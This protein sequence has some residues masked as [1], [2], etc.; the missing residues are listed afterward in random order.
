MIYEKVDLNSEFP[1]LP[2]GGRPAVLEVFCR[3]QLSDSA[4]AK[5]PAMIVCPGGGYWGTAAH[6]GEPVALSML[7]KGIQGFVL[8][9]T[10]PDGSWP[11][12]HL[13]LAAAVLWVRRNADRL[14]VDGN[15]ISVLG[16]SA[17]C[18]LAASFAVN[19]GDRLF[20]ETLGAEREELRVN[21][22]VLCYG[23]LMSEGKFAHEGSIRNLLKDK[24]TPEL[25]EKLSVEKNITEETP[26][27]FIWHTADDEAVPVENSLAVAAAMSAAKRPFE[28]HVYPSG[29]H[30]LSLS[31]WVIRSPEDR[32]NAD[33]NIARWFEDCAGWV[34][35]T[36]GYQS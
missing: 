9:Y 2:F 19:W 16:F 11:Q 36:F 34:L 14:G 13:E 18:H 15:A 4:N 12:Y 35:R 8:W 5:F 17:G 1:G 22:M 30:G 3:S 29:S 10:V 21:G 25:L 20:Y 28:L 26:P 7:G 33:E 23:V 32:K 24:R 6:E 31:T 27:A